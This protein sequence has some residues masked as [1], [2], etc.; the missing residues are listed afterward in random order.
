MRPF[1]FENSFGYLFCSTAHILRKALDDCLAEEGLTSRQWEVLAVLSGQGEL[2]Q[3]QLA[4]SLGIEAPAMAG[5]VSRM[6]RDGWL[7]R[8]ACSEDRRRTLIRP[9]AQS[10]EVWSRSLDCLYRLRDELYADL[11]EEEFATLR[12][13]CGKIRNNVIT[14]AESCEPIPLNMAAGPHV[15]QCTEKSMTGRAANEHSQGKCD[16]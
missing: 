1:D 10:E 13:I 4:A 15:P 12:T 3:H 16:H 7:E 6:E 5:V 9:T 11:T 8:N 2:P 14:S